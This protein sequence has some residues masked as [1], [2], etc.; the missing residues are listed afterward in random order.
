MPRRLRFITL[1]LVGAATLGAAWIVGKSRLGGSTASNETIP[2]PNSDHLSEAESTE[3]LTSRLEFSRPDRDV[4]SAISELMRRGTAV[5]PALIASMGDARPASQVFTRNRDIM[6]GF[7]VGD[8]CFMIIQN[9]IEG[10]RIKPQVHS[11][12]LSPEN[13]ESWLSVRVDATLAQLRVAAAEEALAKIDA[14]ERAGASAPS[15]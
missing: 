9:Q 4:E 3:Q 2:P 12:I 15:L 10:L 6:P 5:F 1:A 13:V 11:Y 8:A 7:T 14:L